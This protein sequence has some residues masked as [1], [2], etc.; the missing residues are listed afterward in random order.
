LGFAQPYDDAGTPLKRGIRAT[1]KINVVSSG[2][3]K[4]LSGIRGTN[5][6]GS[7][8]VNFARRDPD[9]QAAFSLL[10]DRD[11]GWHQIYDI[12]EFIGPA[13]IVKK[14]WT[15]KNELRILKQTATHF[16]HLGRPKKNPLPPNPPTIDQCRNAVVGFLQLWV[17]E[18][19]G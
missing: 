14:K 2:G 13:I 17:L 18:R 16:R 1:A 9:V 19:V 15:N 6:L 7:Y 12:I 3:I 10:G 11:I 8:A 5:T 4:Q